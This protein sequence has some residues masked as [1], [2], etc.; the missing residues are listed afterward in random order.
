MRIVIQHAIGDPAW[1]PS[2]LAPPSVA[3]FARLAE[4]HGY[5]GIA[6]SAS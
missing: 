5:A 6:S 3:D 2:V 1:H 4:R